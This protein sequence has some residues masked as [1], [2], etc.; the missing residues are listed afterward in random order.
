L[1]FCFKV[2]ALIVA[3][4]ILAVTCD[5]ILTILGQ[6]WFNTGKMTEATGTQTSRAAGRAERQARRGAIKEAR[7]EMKQ[8]LHEAKARV[9]SQVNEPL[10]VQLASA[11]GGAIGGAF[12]P[13]AMSF[14]EAQTEGGRKVQ[15]AL[16][17]AQVIGT[18]IGAG[19]FGLS[20]DL[21]VAGVTA[22][23]YFGPQLGN[24]VIRFSESVKQ[25]REE[26]RGLA[27]EERKKRRVLVESFRNEPPAVQEGMLLLGVAAKAFLPSGLPGLFNISARKMEKLGKPGERTANIFKTME[28]AG[29]LTMGVTALTSGDLRVMAAGAASVVIGKM[30]N[31][32]VETYDKGRQFQSSKRAIRDEFRMKRDA[33]RRGEMPVGERPIPDW[34]E[35]FEAAV[36]EERESGGESGEAP[37]P[38]SLAG[39]QFEPPADY[40]F[41]AGPS[42]QPA[43]PEPAAQSGTRTEAEEETVAGEPGGEET[44]GEGFGPFMDLSFLSEDE[45]E[46]EIEPGGGLEDLVA[47]AAEPVGPPA[48][49]GSEEG[50]GSGGLDLPLTEQEELDKLWGTMKA[51]LDEAD[52]AVGKGPKEPAESEPKEPVQSGPDK[53]TDEGGALPRKRGSKRSSL[54]DRGVEILFGGGGPAEEEQKSAKPAGE[55]EDE[56]PDWL[57]EARE[58]DRKRAARPGWLPDEPV[59]RPEEAE[60][61]LDRYR[62]VFRIWRE[63]FLIWLRLP[64]EKR[65]EA[66]KLINTW[67]DRQHLIN[68]GIVESDWIDKNKP[69]GWDSSREVVEKKYEGLSAVAVGE[70]SDSVGRVYGRLN[71][72]DRVAS[73]RMFMIW[74]EH[75]DPEEK[76]EA[77]KRWV[78]E[79]ESRVEED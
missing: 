52:R 3:K 28:S 59:A 77:E 33:I 39:D 72:D 42:G 62:G 22:L 30:G 40:L 34:L 67:L 12:F 78:E 27:K 10:P 9:H 49:P 69:K 60:T 21:R 70:V 17:R 75:L 18:A 36:Q 1:I 73:R 7:W 38:E 8:K 51:E 64:E 68:R 29:W 43:E 11:L 15:F 46:D 76:R 65:E 35:G 4:K 26:S 57:R 31:L 20:G 66:R 6:V 50:A 5:Y 61:L 24:A 74:E 63:T 47:G 79:M 14:P 44:D 54:A 48:E 53:T 58:E 19:A 2:M 37:V 13:S 41:D 32:A 16:D 56:G 55:S 25:K 45:G 71:Y 23:T